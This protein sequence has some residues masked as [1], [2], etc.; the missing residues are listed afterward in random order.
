MCFAVAVATRDG[1]SVVDDGGSDGDDI[2][3]GEEARCRGDGTGYEHEHR[4]IRA[5]ARS[6][7]GGTWQDTSHGVTGLLVTRALSLTSR[8]IRSYSWRVGSTE[9]NVRPFF[10]T[11]AFI[12]STNTRD[13]DDA[14]LYGE[15]GAAVVATS[16]KK[17]LRLELSEGSENE[18]SLLYF[19]SLNIINFASARV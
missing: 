1:L 9:H 18:S 15:T 3:A 16:G 10:S 4:K 2:R 17:Q 19:C 5:R 6:R 11:T 7:T 12:D 13:D 8:C 14:F